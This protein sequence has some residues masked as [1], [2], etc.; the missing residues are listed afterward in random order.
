MNKKSITKKIAALLLIVILTSLLDHIFIPKYID[1]NIDGR[2]TA[3]FYNESVPL[4]VIGLGSSTMYN[5]MSPVALYRDYGFTSYVRSNASQT[6]WQ[7][8]YLLKD[9]IKYNKPKLV[10]FDVSFMKYGEEF[11]EEPSNR[12]TI[13]HM[14]DPLAKYNAVMASKYE[15]EQ[16]ISYYLP[17]LRYH[18]RWKSLSANDLKYAYD[19]PEVT[20]DG[21]IMESRVP[22]EQHIYAPEALEEAVFPQKAEAYLDKIIELCR[23]EDIQLLLMKTPTYVNSWHAEYDEL[24]TKKASENGIV[25]INFDT[26]SENAGITVRTDYIDDGEHFNISGAEKFNHILGQYL[27]DNYELPEHSSENEIKSVWDEKVQK[28]ETEKEKALKEHEQYVTDLGL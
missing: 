28:Y 20:F 18:S 12:K 21:F 4:D 10:I 9:A 14:R 5:A 22:K 15:Q 17:I 25:Y 11:I 19:Y 6:V 13:E 23:R 1:E 16:P 2:I 27:K 24:L 7:S 3:E 8:Y 26:T